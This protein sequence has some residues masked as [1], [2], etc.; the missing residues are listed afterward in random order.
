MKFNDK[1]NV[2]KQVLSHRTKVSMRMS[3]IGNDLAANGR[4]HDNSY[5][6]TTESGLI[7]M[8]FESN[9]NDKKKRSLELLES[10]HDSQND[11]R[12][13]H[14]DN[15]VKDMNILQLIQY[16]AD[17]MASVE[18]EIEKPSIEDY[19]KYVMSDIEN[20]SDDL[21]SVI[22]NSIMYLLN[23]NG[24]LSKMIERKEVEGYGS[25]KE[26]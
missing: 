15:G 7:N 23:K 26:K 13:N 17:K 24:V 22:K 3:L 8:M 12:I 1:E 18:E 10:I 19:E 21:K 9:D 14:H 16:V 4:R 2:L 20:A 25:Y 11:Y 5:S 6:S